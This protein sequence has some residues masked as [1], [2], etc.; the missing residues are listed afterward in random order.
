VT[1]ALTEGIQ[2]TLRDLAREDVVT[3]DP[4]T[5]ATDLADAMREENVGSVV[6]TESRRPVGLVTDRDIAMQ[7]CR[8][9]VDP[10]AM[11]ARDVMTE[12]LFTV[13]A[14]AGIYEA[15]RKTSEANVR[16]VPVVEDGELW[17]IVTLDDFFVLLTGE[18]G[19]LSSVVQSE[20]PPY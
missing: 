18:L 9:A 15:I 13:E 11:T 12:D 17:G 5:P 19:E 10:A 3:A 4:D 14:D 16:R 6:I 2:M 8:E 20:S 1:V 7:L